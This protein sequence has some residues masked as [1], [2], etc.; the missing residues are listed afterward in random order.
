MKCGIPFFNPHK[1][2]DIL[3]EDSEHYLGEDV[4]TYTRVGF[5]CT[6]CYDVIAVRLLFTRSHWLLSNMTCDK[7]R[8]FLNK[9]GVNADN[10]IIIPK[11]LKYP[12]AGTPVP[13]PPPP[14]IIEGRRL[15]NMKQ[16]TPTPSPNKPPRFG[17]K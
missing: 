5:I 13:P 15:T 14:A 10:K 8:L 9:F 17:T 2:I 4:I 12:P 3:Q 11:H 16:Y 6:K 7:G 1:Y